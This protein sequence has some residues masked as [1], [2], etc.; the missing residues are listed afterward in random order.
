M[1]A[2]L[3]E[4]D[5]LIRTYAVCIVLCS[6]EYFEKEF[7]EKHKNLPCVEGFHPWGALYHWIPWLRILT[8]ET[9][10][11]SNGRS[12]L[13]RG[14]AHLSIWCDVTNQIICF[15]VTTLSPWKTKHHHQPRRPPAKRQCSRYM[16]TYSTLVTYVFVNQHQNRRLISVVGKNSHQWNVTW[17]TC[18]MPKDTGNVINIS[19]CFCFHFW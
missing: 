3:T 19:F 9:H 15:A 16:L 4:N 10:Q 1:Q 17:S 8:W 11:S 18:T 6:H 5:W 12:L 2:L 14:S 13:Q 7:H